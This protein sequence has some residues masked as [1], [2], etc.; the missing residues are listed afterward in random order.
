[1]IYLLDKVLESSIMLCEAL[2]MS[3]KYYLEIVLICP[4]FKDFVLKY[5]ETFVILS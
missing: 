5:P 2:I 4:N 3:R 1:M